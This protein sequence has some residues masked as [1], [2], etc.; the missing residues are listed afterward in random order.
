MHVTLLITNR[1]S[2]S[3][4]T[5]AAADLLFF[6]NN[7]PVISGFCQDSASVMRVFQTQSGSEYSG[8]SDNDEDNND[9]IKICDIEANSPYIVNNCDDLKM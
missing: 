4:S 6:E 3:S 2:C 8:T 5:Q 7:P 1:K 9:N